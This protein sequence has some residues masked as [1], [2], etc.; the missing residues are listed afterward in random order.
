MDK[1]SNQC[2]ATMIVIAALI[3]F[4]SRKQVVDKNEVK[5]MFTDMVERMEHNPEYPKTIDEIKN[6]IR[7]I[8]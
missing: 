2:D 8:T 6:F 7:L 5:K 3:K 1:G 4:L